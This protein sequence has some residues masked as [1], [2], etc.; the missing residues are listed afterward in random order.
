[1]G[2]KE[3]GRPGTYDP[4]SHPCLAAYG[5]DDSVS[6]FAG[7]GFLLVRLPNRKPIT[8]PALK[9]KI[10][11]T[12]TMISVMGPVDGRRGPASVSR[13]LIISHSGELELGSGGVWW[14]QLASLVPA[15]RGTG[16]R[17]AFFK[18]F[19]PN[20]FQLLRL[21]IQVEWMV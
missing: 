20:R 14:K 9:S 5:K 12:A 2:G 10:I 18:L 6:G 11:T 21:L 8:A 3:I 1:M 4:A 15:M 17:L 19:E 13:K 16:I 7:V